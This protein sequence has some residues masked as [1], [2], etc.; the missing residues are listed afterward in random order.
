MHK[1]GS[2]HSTWRGDVLDANPAKGT[3][4]YRYTANMMTGKQETLEGQGLIQFAARSKG[5]FHSGRGYFVDTGT[6]MVKCYYDMNRVEKAEAA[7]LRFAQQ[8]TKV[9]GEYI[10]KYHEREKLGRDIDLGRLPETT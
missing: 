9:R 8:S 3:L 7:E 6:E 5:I 4:S 1:D 2:I 10:R